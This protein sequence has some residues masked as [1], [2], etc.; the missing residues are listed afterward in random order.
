MAPNRCLCNA[1]FG[2]QTSLRNH[3]VQLGHS[4]RCDC[5]QF[6]ANDGKLKSHKNM[7]RGICKA[8]PFKRV[9]IDL[10]HNRK[11]APNHFWCAVC[12]NKFF[13]SQGER[14][15]HLRTHHHACS[16]CLQVFA[17][18]TARQAHQRSTGHCFCLECD[19]GSKPFSTLQ[20]LAHHQCTVLQNDKYECI[21]CGANFSNETVFVNHFNSER[22]N[23]IG[24]RRVMEDQQTAL[25]AVQLA[26]VEEAN[27][28]C[29][30]CKK[31]FVDAA[32]YKQHKASTKHKAPKFAIKCPCKKDFNLVSALVQHLESGGCRSHVTRNQLNAAIYRYDPDRRITMDRHADRFAGMSIAGSSTAS[33]MAPS[34]SASILEFSFR[35][36]ST[37]SSRSSMV[38]DRI[39]TPD[40]SDATSTISSHGGVILTPDGS[41]DVST[42]SK[43]IN[44]PPA[45][46]TTSNLSGGDARL[47]PSARS[48]RSTSS[49]DS[50][51]VF[52]PNNSTVS[53]R[54]A[55]STSAYGPKSVSD[56]DDEGEEESIFTPPGSSTDGSY[57][58]WFYVHSSTIPTPSSSS[59]DGSSVATIRYDSNS[60]SWSCA[61]CSRTFTTRNDLCQHM[62]SA[63]HSKKIF[64]CPTIVGNNAVAQDREFRTMSGLVQHIEDEACK[65]GEDAM[66]AVLGVIGKPM[67]K[68]NASITS[69]EK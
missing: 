19:G 47:P 44:T 54:P 65:M 57:E 36:L 67:R 58:D 12:P 43:S 18:P 31:H 55:P 46:D 63:V 6:F 35:S 4:I 15:K 28:W 20:D 49:S 52:T 34:D 69:L 10:T 21:T 27:L 24:N 40:E 17:N 48:G 1:S 37:D 33:S 11:N 62:E 14:A 41:D 59:I 42:D 64:H 26:K 39:S 53:A 50:E 60:K 9:V 2:T 66:P 29:E 30:E 45:S 68:F 61:E 7:P 22:H 13:R 16:T 8:R 3:A 25:A 23:V 56:D 38:R 5:G 32:A 51:S